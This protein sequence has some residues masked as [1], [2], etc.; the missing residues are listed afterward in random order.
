[1]GPR[2]QGLGGGERSEGRGLWY[3]EAAVEALGLGLDLVGV[4][5]HPLVQDQRLAPLLHQHVG[6]GYV[7]APEGGR[8]V[9]GHEAH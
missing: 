5:Q 8:G 4:L 9:H 1:M 6:L 3:L 7:E 2:K